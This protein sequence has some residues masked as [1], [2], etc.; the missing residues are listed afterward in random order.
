MAITKRIVCV[1]NSRKL[2]GRCIAGREWDGKQ[3]GA[4][5]RPVSAREHEEVSENERQYEDGSD[6]KVLDIID[7]PVYSN[8]GRGYQSENWLIDDLQYWKR[9]GTVAWRDLSKLVDVSGPLW[10]NGYRTYSGRN[11]RV[12][13]AEAAGL[14]DSL[15]LLHLPAL[16]LAVFAPGAAFCNPRRNV[17]GRFEYCG[18]RYALRV[19]DPVAERTYLAKPDGN[20]NVGECFVTVSL[21][22]AYEGYC[23]KLIA[24][25]ITT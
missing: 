18:T 7:I 1:A 11:D 2:S 25:V 14:I 21:G 19:T 9:L 6:P 24:A 13:L 12:P 20:Y 23:Y 17:Q 3:A 15:R 16:E 5:V 22:E 8:R 4:W 10:I